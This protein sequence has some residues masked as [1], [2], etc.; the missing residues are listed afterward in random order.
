M[1][2]M[3]LDHTRDFFSSAM[4]D[5]ADPLRSWP[6]LFATRWITHL[7]A[8]GFIALAGTSAYLQ[9]ARGKTPAHL[10]TFLATRGLWLIFLDLTVISFAWSFTLRAPYLQVIWAIGGSM[11]A[12]ALLQRFPT[13]VVAVT[14]AAITLF[15]NLLD[16]IRS[17]KLDRAAP[18]WTL[19]HQPGFL[20]SHGKPIALVAYPLLP[21][22]GV[23]CLGYAFGA[24]VVASPAFRRKASTALGIAFL[25]AFVLVR[26][27][28]SYGDVHRWHPLP[29][30]RQNIMDF[31]AVEKYP[32]SL[33]YVLVTLG[34]LL[35]LYVLLDVC[36]SRTWAPKLRAFV[37]IYGRV[38]FF[39][40][41]LHIYLI[42][43]VALLR[44]HLQHGDWRLWVNPRLI[45]YEE[46]PPGWGFSLPVVYL[47]WLAV[48]LFLFY[49]CLWFGHIK[50]KYK[51]WWLSYL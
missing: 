33:Q 3:A 42:H 27:A 22:I 19:L 48:V 25:A 12:L 41:V 1:L 39:Y 51:L 45:W 5:P 4:V 43:G 26:S 32:P 50:T 23:M 30:T 6:T 8:P 18:A 29:T 15:H 36:V 9:R 44:T 28:N 17:D 21:W 16:P 13:S 20:R 24:W 35:L 10:T 2:L 11:I 46:V 37:E 38:P 14:G 49:P 7:C 47:I 34:L 31:L 40:Y